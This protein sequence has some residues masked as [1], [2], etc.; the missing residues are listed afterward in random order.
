[1]EAELRSMRAR[2]TA[3]SSRLGQ[4]AAVS[5]Q[6]SANRVRELQEA[7]AAQ[8]ARVLA[9]N[10]QRG[11][12]SVLQREVDSA[13][14]AFETV[15]ASAAQSRLQ[16]LSTQSNVLFLGSAVE[17]LE[18]SG[19][20]PLQAMLVALGGGLLLGMAGAL[21]AELANRRVRSVEDLEMVTQLPILGVVPAPKSRITPLRL[22]N[23]PRR[24]ALTPQ[25]SL[26]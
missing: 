10:K 7:L 6:A 5:S 19:P 20:T 21:L 18:P 13:Q 2:L 8:R 9:T 22:A 17:P 11:E 16:S 24:L 23:T 25:R 1:M 4:A 3:E 14:K 12:L 26:A 15:S